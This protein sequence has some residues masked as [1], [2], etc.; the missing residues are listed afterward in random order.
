MGKEEYLARFADVRKISRGMSGD[1]K[2]RVVLD[3]RDCLLRISEASE[4]ERKKC[5][6]E[7]LRQ[8]SAAGLP[9]PECLG[10]EMDG[11]HVYTLLS[12]VEGDEAEK[13]LPREN[14]DVQYDYGRQAGDILRRVHENSP[15]ID[16]EKGWYDRYFDVIGPR[17]DAFRKE[18]IPFEGSEAVLEFIEENKHLM[19]ERP[20]RRHHGDYHMGNLI[21]NDGKLWVIDW[22]T[23]DFD[24]VGDPWYEFNRIGSEYPAFARG[25]IDGYFEGN[26]PEKFWRLFALYFAA[27]AITSIVWAKYWAPD[28]LENIMKLNRRIIKMFDGMKN[29]VPDWYR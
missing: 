29:P 28:E 12:W 20:L 19:K 14:A 15:E 21:V 11:E 16:S 8:L 2:F 3:G 25:Q 13:A 27:S 6:Y 22:H 7:Y 5:E 18:G 24:N 17:I 23:V 9:V 10:F 26:V 4:Y 1:E